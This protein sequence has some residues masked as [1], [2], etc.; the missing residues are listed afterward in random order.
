MY[1][2]NVKIYIDGK[3][4]TFWIFGEDTISPNDAKHSWT[5][6][7]ISQFVKSKGNHII[8]VRAEAG[9]GRCELVVTVE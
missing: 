5:N 6:I 2:E 3:D 7:D 1:P 8:E 4:C 9:T